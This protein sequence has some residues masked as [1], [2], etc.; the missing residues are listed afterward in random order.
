MMG[1][2]SSA[3]AASKRPRGVSV[4][5]GI[6]EDTE[7]DDTSILYVAPSHH[8]P[9]DPF[10]PIFPIPLPL[11]LDPASIMLAVDTKTEVPHCDFR[12]E[13]EGSIISS[14]ISQLRSVT[15]CHPPVFAQSRRQRSD[16]FQSRDGPVQ[17]DLSDVRAGATKH[18]GTYHGFHGT[19]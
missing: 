12:D 3:V 10:P 1:F 16:F 8:P 6:P 13:N 7:P 15:S 11:P 17:S 19:P 2:F 9:F 4:G 5:E 18:V 14:L